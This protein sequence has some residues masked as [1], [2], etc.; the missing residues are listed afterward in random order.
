MCGTAKPD[1]RQEL[2]ACMSAFSLAAA[3]VPAEGGL[4]AEE[5]TDEYSRAYVTRYD[6]CAAPAAA[7]P[8]WLFCTAD[9]LVQ[10]I[11]ADLGQPVL[12]HRMNPV[13]PAFTQSGIGDGGGAGARNIDGAAVRRSGFHNCF[14]DTISRSFFEGQPVLL[15]LKGK[16]A[17]ALGVVCAVSPDGVYTVETACVCDHCCAHAPR[18]KCARCKAVWYCGRGCQADGWKAHQRSCGA[19]A[20]DGSA[21][22]PTWADKGGG[23][24]VVAHAEVAAARLRPAVGRDF[25]AVQATQQTGFLESLGERVGPDPG[26]E[27][28]KAEVPTVIKEMWVHRGLLESMDD[29]EYEG[30]LEALPWAKSFEACCEHYKAGIDAGGGAVGFTA[31]L[32]TLHRKDAQL[33]S[34]CSIYSCVLAAAV[35]EARADYAGLTHAFYNMVA[36]LAT[37]AIPAPDCYWY[38]HDTDADPSQRTTGLQDK[39]PGWAALVQGAIT[40]TPV[41]GCRPLGLHCMT[42]VGA[43][44]VMPAEPKSLAPEGYRLEMEVQESTIVKFVST[45]RDGAGFHTAV[46]T[47]LVNLA[48]PPMALFTVVDVQVGSFEFDGTEGLLRRCKKMY[49]GRAPTAVL[50]AHGRQHVKRA[51][52]VEWLVEVNPGTLY[53][54]L[55]GGGD[56]H[57]N[58]KSMMDWFHHNMLPPGVESTIYTVNW[59]LVTVQATYLLPAAAAAAAGGAGSPAL[60][61]AAEVACGGGGPGNAGDAVHAKLMAD[62]TQLG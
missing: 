55:T 56:E 50:D 3:P 43:T 30:L 40:A 37:D 26:G 57:P 28:W 7:A 36:R 16:G 18:S 14:T 49:G 58:R 5:E 22:A 62:S 9:E 15:D 46:Y 24:V 21:S 44:S 29:P 45:G 27:C 61:A 12:P 41:G 54:H 13:L 19:A 11:E 47:D 39:E 17:P 1:E 32:R 48:F 6:P 4:G 38:L 8:A 59:T 60:A 33:A 51:H 34:I 20:D 53:E 52:L 42:A 23:I 25:D 2:A 31:R 35:R 10:Q